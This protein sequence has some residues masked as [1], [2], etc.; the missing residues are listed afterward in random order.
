M[1]SVRFLASKYVT[2]RTAQG[3]FRGRTPRNNSYVLGRF[4]DRIGPDMEPGDLRRDHFERW[5]E[6]PAALSTKHS[7]FSVVRAWV[8]WMVEHDYLRRDPTIGVRPPRLPRSVPHR[9]DDTKV[10]LLLEHCPDIRGEAMVLLMAESALRCCE[11]AN[12]EIGDVDFQA[13]T[14]RVTGKGGHERVVPLCEASASAVRR[15]LDERPSPAGPMFRSYTRTDRGLSAQYISNRVCRWM[16][17]AGLR[18]ER[19]GDA[20]G[21]HPSAHWMRHGA[22]QAVIE[23]G[24]DPRTVQTLLGHQSLATTSRYTGLAQLSEMRRAMVGRQLGSAKG[25]RRGVSRCDDSADDDDLS[26]DGAEVA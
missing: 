12:L 1:P 15:Y 6:R 4:C 16:S 17:L 13:M 25:A 21:Q 24:G 8:Q 10:S 23:A 14:I 20:R 9:V 22:A 18:P 5:L 11:V 3:R 26:G 2:S 19:V 7:E